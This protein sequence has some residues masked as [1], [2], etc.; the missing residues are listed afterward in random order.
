MQTCLIDEVNATSASMLAQM[1]KTMTEVFEAK[2]GGGQ[3]ASIRWEE[4]SVSGV[5]CSTEAGDGQADLRRWYGRSGSREKDT[6]GSWQA[7]GC[8]S[9]NGKG[10]RIVP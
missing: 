1:H 6:R 10:S 5:S 3:R 7:V 8:V 4:D 2:E 9:L